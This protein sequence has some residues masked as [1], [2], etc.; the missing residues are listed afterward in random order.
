[1]ERDALFDLAVNRS[2]A[3]AKSL[4]LETINKEKLRQG[5]ELWYLKTRFAYRISLG[6]I[7]EILQSYPGSGKWLGGKSGSW[8]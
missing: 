1:M 7:V 2:L 4:G 8:F 3:Y 6:D 5:L